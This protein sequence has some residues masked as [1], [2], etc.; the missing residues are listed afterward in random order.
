VVG[1]LQHTLAPLGIGACAGTTHPRGEPL[2]TLA[3]D[4]A[5]GGKVGVAI[6]VRDAV[7]KKRVR[8]EVDLTS[9][10]ADGRELAIAIEADELLRAC[11][12]E[13]AL[14]TARSRGA[15]RRGDVAGSVAQVLAPVRV[16]NPGAFG[17]R[18]A[19]EV[20]FGGATLFG[21]DTFARLRL[22]DRTG[23]ELAAEIRASPSV[24]TDHGRVGALAAG[25]GVSVLFRVAG[26][27]GAS[28]DVGAGVAGSWLQFRGEAAPGSRASPY[29]NLL[30]VSR[31]RVV[32]RLALGR[33]MRAAVGFQA[34]HALVG[35]AARD[36]GEVVR[37]ASG[38]ALGATIGLETP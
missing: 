23:L 10:P 5:T 18:A 24:A 20:F 36:S 32:G 37:S 16:Q 14:D 31:A 21:A 33:W 35:V 2:A 17:A 26:S 30:L 6:E 29:G 3:I 8:R 1:D 25:G 4:L 7:T 34:G 22:G 13:I 15:E 27:D 38:L 11:W 12:A 28:I 9:I 19:G